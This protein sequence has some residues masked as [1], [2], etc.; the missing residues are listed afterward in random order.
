MIHACSVITKKSDMASKTAPA[1]AQTVAVEKE[2]ISPS[3]QVA[4]GVKLL[5]CGLIFYYKTPNLFDVKVPLEIGGITNVVLHGIMS[6]VSLVVALDYFAGPTRGPGSLKTAAVTWLKRG[7]AFK[8]PDSNNPDR[9]MVLLAAL[10]K[11]LGEEVIF[12]MALLT[13]VPPLGAAQDAIPFPV[14]TGHIMSVWTYG[15]YRGGDDGEMSA[16]AVIA[17]IVYASAS[18]FGGA[19]A[20][21]L[22]NFVANVGF[23][24]LYFHALQRAKAQDAAPAR[25]ERRKAAKEEKKAAKKSK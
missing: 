16:F 23:V 11:A 19:A 3:T 10:F 25:D 20:A 17:G 24:S 5:V 4:S 13:M 12:R 15:W 21:V 9:P 7:E 22:A 14:P 6:G 1:D 18:Y 8:K 2:D